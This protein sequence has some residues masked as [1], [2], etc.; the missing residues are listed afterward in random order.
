[1]DQELLRIRKRNQNE[2][3]YI[4][5]YTVCLICFSQRIGF[6]P[7]YAEMNAAWY[8]YGATDDGFDDA[9][10]VGVPAA[11]AGGVEVGVPAAGVLPIEDGVPA[12][13]GWW[14]GAN[15][16]TWSD[17][18]TSTVGGRGSGFGSGYGA[19]SDNAI[20][21]CIFIFVFYNINLSNS[22]LY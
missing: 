19:S 12:A 17:H 7:H 2:C 11:G 5:I 22:K 1:M 18:V 20:R 10:E 15:P 9:E 13:A 8:G 4:Y 16:T 6:V 21:G 3:I 14:I